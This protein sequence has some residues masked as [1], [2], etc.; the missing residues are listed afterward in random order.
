MRD[1]RFH[2]FPERIIEST[3]VPKI[4][5]RVAILPWFNAWNAKVN[6]LD[7]CAVW[8][9]GATMLHRC[10][11]QSPSQLAVTVICAEETSTL[12]R[13]EGHAHTSLSTTSK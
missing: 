3:D 13:L 5:E 12:Q 1:A 2:D 8:G 6:L 4:G 11:L 10:P 9:H 7:D